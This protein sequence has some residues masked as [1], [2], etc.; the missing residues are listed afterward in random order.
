[1]L[2]TFFYGTRSFAD[3]KA[4]TRIL[5]GAFTIASLITITN[6]YGITDWGEMDYGDNN[7]YEAN[8]VY[9][10]FGHANET[11]ALIAFFL[12]AYV[13]VAMSERR[14][15]D[16]PSTSHSMAKSSSGSTEPFLEGR[17]RTWP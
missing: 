14:F 16:L 7:L 2:L 4:L 6:V 12:P 15:C 3:T 9:G 10:F 5:L 1:V 13:A 8:R 17:S 11:G